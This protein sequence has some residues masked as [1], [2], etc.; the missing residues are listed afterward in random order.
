MKIIVSPNAF[1]GSMSGFEAAA[2]IALGVSRVIPDARILCMPVAD[3]G[4]GLVDILCQALGGKMIKEIVTGPLR[5]KVNA[6]YCYIAESRTGIVEMAKASGLALLD[7]NE[8]NPELTT[9]YGTGQLIKKCLDRGAERIVV[10][11]GGSATCDGGIGAAAAFGYRFYDDSG[12]E[13]DPIGANL[14]KIKNI[15]RTSVDT[16]FET[17]IIEA[18]CDVTNPLTG[19][20]GAS[21]VYSPQKGADKEQVVR[22]DEG[23]QNLAS[24]ILRDLGIAVDMIPGAGAAG[25]LGAGVHAFF[26]GR[27]RKGIDLVMDLIELQDKITGADLVITGEGR[28][29]AQTKF[30]KAPAGVAKIAKKNGVPCIALCGSIGDNISELYDQGIDAVFSICREP[31]G[32]DKAIRYGEH[33][34]ADAAEQA[35]RL[36]IISR[37]R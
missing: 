36:F 20:Q 31:M 15:D 17:I 37:E 26:K 34:L 27:L 18:V 22:L 23:L 25:G 8:K 28:M 32:L 5:H 13:L 2:A 16:R 9:T 7:D 3:G 6:S 33:L 4:D 12:K 24:V 21:F 14:T 30:D 19:I 11:L 35:M 29:D 1:K 10:G